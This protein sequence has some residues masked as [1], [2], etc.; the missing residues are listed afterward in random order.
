M[1]IT[2]EMAKTPKR[3][4]KNSRLCLE[5]AAIITGMGITDEEAKP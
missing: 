3:R 1:G 5:K 2:D 4:I